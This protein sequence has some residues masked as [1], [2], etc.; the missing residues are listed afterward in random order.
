MGTTTTISLAAHELC[1]RHK[2]EVYD[3]ADVPVRRERALTHLIR[4]PKG[5][6]HV[7][8]SAGPIWSLRTV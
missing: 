6:A 2:R 7:P 3:S 4:R 5:T 8:G 1:G